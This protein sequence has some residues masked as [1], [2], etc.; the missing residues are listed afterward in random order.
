MPLHWSS[1]GYTRE[2]QSFG[3]LSGNQDFAIRPSDLGT[4]AVNTFNKQN[5]SLSRD[6]LQEVEPNSRRKR[7]VHRQ[8]HS[9]PSIA[10]PISDSSNMPDIKTFLQAQALL[11]VTLEFDNTLPQSKKKGLT[12]IIGISA[13]QLESCIKAKYEIL[14]ILNDLI[15]ATANLG[16]PTDHVVRWLE[17][18]DTQNSTNK[19]TTDSAYQSQLTRLGGRNTPKKRRKLN[20][21]DESVPKPY[22]CTHIDSDDKHCIHEFSNFT[23]W[24]RH[25]ETHWPQ[26]RWECLIQGSNTT[27]SCHICSGNIDLAGHQPVNDHAGCVTGRPRKGHSFQRKDKLMLHV[28]EKHDCNANIDDWYEDVISKWKKQCGFCGSVFTTWEARC[29]DVGQHFM[30]G[31][32]MITDW[33]DPWPTGSGTFSH[34][35]DDDNDNNDNDGNDDN[36]GEAGGD[37]DNQDDLYEA[38]PHNCADKDL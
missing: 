34:D 10:S 11:G 24:K 23:D 28:K 27:A 5:M 16:L 17:T 4:F 15:S 20:E 9:R 32:R 33:K 26:R 7:K 6:G 30:E 36:D 2:S 31:K 21:R 29:D 3:G 14:P 37:E 8:K 13:A 25:E 22:Q 1:S 38:D 18:I 12:E 35:G 19:S